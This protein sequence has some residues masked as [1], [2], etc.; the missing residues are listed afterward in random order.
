MPLWCVDRSAR[1]TE[2]LR[3][4]RNARVKARPFCSGAQVSIFQKEV[5][6]RILSIA[7]VLMLTSVSA[8]AQGA[9][10]NAAANLAGRSPRRAYAGRRSRLP[11]PATPPSSRATKASKCRPGSRAPPRLA[12]AQPGTC[13][14]SST[15][16][17]SSGLTAR[18]GANSRKAWSTSSSTRR[19]GRK[20]VNAHLRCAMGATRESA[21]AVPTRAAF[22]TREHGAAREGALAHSA[23]TTR[24][25]ALM[26]HPTKRSD[27][28]RL[29]P[30]QSASA[31]PF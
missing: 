10:S 13:S 14:A 3:L 16:G 31:M 19:V 11:S 8:Y 20:R 5:M 4:S 25:N 18:G 15:G 1:R 12:P 21:C 22:G 27:A 9:A 17:P 29:I 24:V 2:A 7:A 30:H 28:V 6:M 23:S 26:A